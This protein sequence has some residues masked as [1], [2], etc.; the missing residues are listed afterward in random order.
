VFYSGDEETEQDKDE[1]D[2]VKP[3]PEKC[4]DSHDGLQ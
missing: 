1:Q 3:V 2:G 4:G